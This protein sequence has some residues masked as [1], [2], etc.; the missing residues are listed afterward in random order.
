MIEPDTHAIYA[1][2]RPKRG[3]VPV[4]LLAWSA[5]VLAMLVIIGVALWL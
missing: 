1:A 5:F 2:P 4:V 3:R